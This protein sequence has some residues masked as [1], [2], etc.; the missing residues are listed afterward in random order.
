MSGQQFVQDCGVGDVAAHRSDLVEAR[1]H[2]DDA[3]ARDRPVG[4]LDADGSGERGGLADGSA[5][6]GAHGQRGLESGEGCSCA[7]G[8]TAGDV[9][10]VPW[11]AGVAEGRVLGRRAHGEFVEVG[12]AEHRQ[13]GG[14]DLVVHRRFVGRDPVLEHLRPGGRTRAF[15][16]DEVLQRDRDAGQG[17]DVLTGGALGVDGLRGLQGEFVGDGDEGVEVILGGGDAVEVGL[18]DFDGGELAGLQ[19]C[20][21]FEGALVRQFGHLIPPRGSAGRGTCRPRR[22]G[23]RPVPVR[24]TASRPPRRG[25]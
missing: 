22:P 21:E 17:V 19:S 9:F 12:L 13:T 24:W 11:V 25:A 18:R 23:P 20:G 7:A 2:G 10:E 8:G 5:G 3:E 6:V 14:L 15:G 4:W 16:D 1:G